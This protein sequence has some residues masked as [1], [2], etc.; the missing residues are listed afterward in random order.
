M[1]ND[2]DR[3]AI[4]A[5]SNRG[6]KPAVAEHIWLQGPFEREMAIALA[7]A[8]NQVNGQMWVYEA[9][10][11]ESGFAEPKRTIF[12]KD[13][14]ADPG[15]LTRGPR[16]PSRDEVREAA[17]DALYAAMGAEI[18]QHPL[19]RGPLSRPKAK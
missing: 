15:L 6:C 7:G 3:W 16:K 5:K 17:E 11:V 14:I 13:V 10:A 8:A 2:S 12:L 9:K 19:G 4:Y 1:A 18:E